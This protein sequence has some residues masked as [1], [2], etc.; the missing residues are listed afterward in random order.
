MDDIESL[1]QALLQHIR[2][3]GLIKSREFSIIE[4]ILDI[5]K[6]RR[7]LYS[8]LIAENNQ[9]QR[10]L[11]DV[12]TSSHSSIENLHIS[13]K[14]KLESMETL[15]NSKQSEIHQLQEIYRS[16]KYRLEENHKR[17][18]LDEIAKLKSKYSQNLSKLESRI[19]ALQESNLCRDNEQQ[20]V[21]IINALTEK[22]KISANRYKSSVVLLYCIR[23]DESMNSHI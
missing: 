15:L 11:E 3:A 13:H 16:D 5:R 23:D 21:E 8:S 22:H 18:R 10:E 7:Q 12:K 4:E 17:D 14:N 6:K 2:V 1:E 19:E 9:I 20:S